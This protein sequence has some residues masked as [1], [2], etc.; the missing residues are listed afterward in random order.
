MVASCKMGETRA[1]LLGISLVCAAN[2][3]A[4]D[5]TISSPRRFFLV[6]FHEIVT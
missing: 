1:L 5:V 4:G 3:D 2:A 6:Y